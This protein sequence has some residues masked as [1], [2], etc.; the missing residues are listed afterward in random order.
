M[1]TFGQLGNASTGY[2][3]CGC[4]MVPVQVNG[5]C[6]FFTGTDETA[7][8]DALAIYPNPA[9]E[10]V[11]VQWLMANG[12]SCEIK[13]YSILGEITQTLTMKHLPDEQTG[14]PLTINVSAWP[15]GIYIFQ[16]H[17]GQEMISRKMVVQH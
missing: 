6:F 9:K 10:M 3:P 5:P 8:Q 17:T 13:V 15:D 11:N 12:S 14:E 2:G 7:E 1:G 16:L 4:S